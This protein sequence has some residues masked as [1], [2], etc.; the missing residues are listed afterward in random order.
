MQQL[1]ESHGLGDRIAVDSAGTASH[2]VGERADARAREAAAR[3]GIALTSRARRF[4]ARDFDH[5]DY[6]IAMDRENRSDLETLSSGAD[7]VARAALEVPETVPAERRG[8]QPHA[9]RATIVLLR[10]FDPLSPRDADV[11]DPYYGGERGFEQVLDLCEAAC[12]G[13]LD[14][15]RADWQHAE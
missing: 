13:L 5:F 14:A 1:V 15:I 4:E 2:H 8:L 10:D 3:R 12:R 6:V 9:R 7:E 11:P